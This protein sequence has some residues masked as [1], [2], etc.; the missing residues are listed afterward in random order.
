MPPDAIVRKI[1]THVAKP[2]DSEANVV[3][4][5]A[6]V[7]KLL[8]KLDPKDRPF[9]LVMYCHWALHVDLNK[10]GTILPF[11]KRVDAYFDRYFR[12]D[13]DLAESHRLIRE[14]IFFDT[15][16]AQLRQ[17]FGE[18]GISTEL[19][20]DSRR[21]N[22]FVMHYAGVIEDGSLEM[23]SESPELKN[24]KQVTFTKGHTPM[25]EFVT[26]PF[27]M[28]WT[29]VLR[30]GKVIDVDVTARPAQNGSPEMIGSGLHLRT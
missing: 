9:A 29:V 18:R 25:S 2:I 22:E 23:R 11:L 6:E 19:T 4:L 28:V 26:Q 17:F 5:M 1:T 21:W 8:E 27:A 7:R 10:P 30:D 20:D 15:F 3:Y 14:F 24:V 16:R 13:E 12:G